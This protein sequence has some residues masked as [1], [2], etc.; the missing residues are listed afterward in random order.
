L[1]ARQRNDLNAL[2]TPNGNFEWSINRTGITLISLE[3]VF[4]ISADLMDSIKAVYPYMYIASTSNSLVLSEDIGLCE[5]FMTPEEL[6]E[7][8]LK[9]KPRVWR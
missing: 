6:T 3:S 8:E 2:L 1:T 9:G 4:I 7:F 5:P